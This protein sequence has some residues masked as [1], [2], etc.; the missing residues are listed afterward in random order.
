M[1]EATI[2]KLPVTSPA[3]PYPAI[4]LPI[5]KTTELGDTA[6]SKEPAPKMNR[7]VRYVHFMENMV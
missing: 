1:A 6:Q 3:L 7:D 4:A 5:I 2:T